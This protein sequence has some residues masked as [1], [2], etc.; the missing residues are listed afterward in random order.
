MAV[1]PSGLSNIVA[2]DEDLA[3]FLTQRSHFSREIPKPSAFLPSPVDRESS[4]SRHGIEPKERLF[5]LGKAAAGHR[6]LHGAA[7]I[8]A[9][10]VAAAKLH[11]MATEP[12]AR[13]AAIRGWPWPDD[14]DLRKAQQKER[15][16]VLA[17]RTTALI[18]FNKADGDD[19][20]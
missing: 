4:V 17:S 5:E 9:E 13:H 20:A 3:R 7:I 8:K 12:P 15:A 2:P 1:L 6:T 14:V 18:F 19:L 10:T 11:V 16:I